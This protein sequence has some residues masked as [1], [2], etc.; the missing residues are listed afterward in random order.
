MLF[1]SQ[2]TLRAKLAAGAVA[3]IATLLVVLDAATL[4]LRDVNTEF[5]AF[6]DNEFAAQAAVAQLRLHLGD[7]LRHEK[8]ALISIDDV[9][10]AKA[11]QEHWRSSLQAARTD[12]QTLHARNG[13][14]MAQRLTE[15]LSDYQ[16]AAD[17]VIQ[18]CIDGRIVTATEGYLALAGARQHADRLASLVTQLSA[19]V[20]N[21]GQERRAQAQG[22]SDFWQWA[23]LAI[24]AL[25]TGAFA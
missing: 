16:K 7:V 21:R 1:G 12:L 11:M 10:A 6:A 9:Q 15:L 14:D 20:A 5:A 19:D 4:A 17:P 3:S 25:S 18:G 13:T 22:R 23:M 8:E 24:A 2:T